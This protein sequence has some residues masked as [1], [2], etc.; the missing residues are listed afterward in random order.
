MGH[1]ARSSDGGE[2]E[3]SEANDETK[4]ANKQVVFKILMW[5]GATL[6][7]AL[8]VSVLLTYLCLINAPPEV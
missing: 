5:W 6:P 8:G 4:K 3:E 1:I 2:E 7:V